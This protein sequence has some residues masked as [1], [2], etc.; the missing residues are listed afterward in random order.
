MCDL[1]HDEIRTIK[2]LIDQGKDLPEEFRFKLFK[3]PL[4]AEL[5]WPGKTLDVCKAELPFQVIEHIDAPR[6]NE[7]DYRPYGDGWSN[8]LIWGDNK[9]IMSS[10]RSGKI[11]KEIERAGGIKLIYIYKPR[12]FENLIKIFGT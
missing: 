1:T 6:L 11:R 12:N 4:K 2:E 7:P 10:L 9:L 8:K 5:I 3:Q